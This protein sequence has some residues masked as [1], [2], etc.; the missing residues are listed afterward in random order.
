VSVTQLWLHSRRPLLSRFRAFEMRGVTLKYPSHSWG[1]VRADDGTVILALWAGDIFTDGQ[2]SSCLLWT[3]QGDG[4]HGWTDS[5]SREE[6][7]EHCRLAVQH[8]GAEGLLVYG[9]SAAVD[10]EIVL[11]LRVVRRGADYWA[12]WGSVT[13]TVGS[14]A[15]GSRA[16]EA[17]T[18]YLRRA[19]G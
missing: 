8:G 18:A 4:A 10:P 13:R 3:S 2:G 7:L 1:G 16:P 11:A 17:S 9:D 19:C 6:R 12:K 14:R 5:A 15:I